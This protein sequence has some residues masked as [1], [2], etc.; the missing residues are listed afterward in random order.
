MANP[1]VSAIESLGIDPVELPH[2]EGQVGVGCF[3]DEVVML[4]IKQ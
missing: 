4:S 2:A 1:R 3:D